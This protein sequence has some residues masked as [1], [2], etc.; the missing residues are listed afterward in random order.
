[1][2]LFKAIIKIF[3]ADMKNRKVIV[4]GGGAS[5]VSAII[6]LL[7]AG[8]K[9]ITL[10]EA[11]EYLGGL[12]YSFLREGKFFHT[13]YHQILESDKPLLNLL[14]LVGM[15]DKITWKKCANV[16]YY[17]GKI[18]DLTKLKDFIRF[19]ISLLSKFRFVYFM[20][21]C[22]TKKNWS[23]LEHVSADEWITRLA[24]KE[25]LEKL[26]SPLF[27]IKF[28]LKPNEVSATWV[29]SRL[30][31]KEASCRFGC[32]PGKEW[33]HELF[34]S[35]RKY[36][37]GRGVIIK[38]NTRVNKILHDANKITGVVL[39]DNKILE[40]DI[41]LSTMSPI[42]LNKLIELNDAELNKISYID[43]ISTIISTNKTAQDV[44]WLML[45]SPREFSGGIFKLTDLN[46]TLG[47][48]NEVILN[49]FTNV[50]HGS[51]LQKS[52]K[53]L[54]TSYQNTYKRIYGEDLE[55][56]W[57]KINRIPYVS[58]KYIKGYKNP[59]VRTKFKGLYLTGNFMSYPSVTS[60]GTAIAAGTRSAEA[61]ITDSNE[62]KATI[63]PTM[64]IYEHVNNNL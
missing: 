15:L 26:F 53:E 10:I 30:G 63:Q 9:N 60:T 12:A 2:K 42:V 14:K 41:V 16:I 23:D 29:G 49:F 11:E 20:L 4:I 18:Y 40:A 1:M 13:G 50:D 56:N 6:N 21:I 34:E 35:S 8:F 17:N 37:E 48:N 43:S 51:V 45:M 44:Y 36:L 62:A 46:P 31:A 59:A 5:G 32:L 28:G 39:H 24:G 47:N 55:I 58:A 33:T 7:N 57:Y 64:E 3:G 61:I 22:Y 54:L 27:D 38:T 19:P 25:V 52:D